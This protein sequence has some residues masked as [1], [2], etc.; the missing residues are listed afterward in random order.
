MFSASRKKTENELKKS[1][2]WKRFAGSKKKSSGREKNAK[3]DCE[4]FRGNKR[5]SCGKLKRKGQ[6][7][8]AESWLKELLK[9]RQG[10]D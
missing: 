10:L 3:K 1:V 4:Q 6:R 2:K 5:K 7:R 9:M 8:D